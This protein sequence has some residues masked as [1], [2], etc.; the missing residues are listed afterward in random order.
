MHIKCSLIELTK[1]HHHLY[2]TSH[3]PASLLN[4]II[5]ECAASSKLKVP[6]RIEKTELPS[7]WDL[8]ISQLLPPPKRYPREDPPPGAAW[9]LVEGRS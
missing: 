6:T 2:V 1:H 3:D 4:C 7:G 9:T 8:G 5:D